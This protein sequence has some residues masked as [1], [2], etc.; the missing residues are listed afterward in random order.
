MSAA[1]SSDPSPP[2]SRS[3]ERTVDVSRPEG[4]D[5]RPVFAEQIVER[6]GLGALLQMIETRRAS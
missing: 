6:F 3:D 4:Q 1:V 2:G 5:I